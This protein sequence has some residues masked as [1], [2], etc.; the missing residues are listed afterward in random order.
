[1]IKV[2]HYA[3]LIT[4]QAMVHDQLNV[5]DDRY[6]YSYINNSNQTVTKEVR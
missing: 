5:Q 6:V 4:S 1:M 3:L 2:F